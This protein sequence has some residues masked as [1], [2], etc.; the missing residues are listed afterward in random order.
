MIAET[1]TK[2]LLK[3]SQKSFVWLADNLQIY[4][5]QTKLDGTILYMND[6]TRKAFEF[7]TT[8]EIY[9]TNIADW[10]KNKIDREKR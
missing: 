8:D 2:V 3:D 10:Y 1:N 5:F 6:Y 4:V 9:N 7:D